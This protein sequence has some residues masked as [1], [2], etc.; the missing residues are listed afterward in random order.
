LLQ[1]RA[2]PPV[3]HR[4]LAMQDK[5]VTPQHLELWSTLLPVP[6]VAM[7]GVH[8]PDVQIDAGHQY[9]LNPDHAHKVMQDVVRKIQA[10]LTAHP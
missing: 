6:S 3:L 5:L 9:L 10:H 2:T 4:Y 8:G 7:V 1:W